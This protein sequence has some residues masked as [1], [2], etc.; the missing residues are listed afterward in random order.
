M[1]M[2]GGTAGKESVPEAD[3]NGSTANGIVGRI[4][5]R[6]N[7]VSAA[8]LLAALTGAGLMIATEFA[9][10]RSVQ[11]L[12]ASC[13]DLADAELRESCVTKGAEEHSW[14]LLLL[15]VV[16]ALM[17]WGAFVG[18]SRPAALAL[19]VIG[20][21]VLVIA[22]ATDLPDAGATGV[23]GERFEQAEAK[24]GAG[25]WMEIAGGVLA[26]VT[27]GLGAAGRLGR[28]RLGPRGAEERA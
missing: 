9:T 7:P 11:V 27:G 14:A 4:S 2:T 5:G 10:L 1:S 25:L 17:A 15:G 28:E 20:A 18:R 3:G 24:A 21:A 12:T 16:A 22:L 19:A 6:L 26:L 23:L 8:L 13:A